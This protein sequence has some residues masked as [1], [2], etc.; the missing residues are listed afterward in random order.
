MT[1][2]YIG[3]TLIECLSTD[4]KPDAPDGWFLK[5]IDSGISYIRRNGEWVSLGLGLSFI[6]ATKS[7][8]I[9]TDANGEYTL[10]FDTPF[11]SNDYSIALTCSDTTPQPQN[12]V[13][14]ALVC[15]CA[16]CG[17]KIKTYGSKSGNKWPGV[18][19]SWLATRNYNP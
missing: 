7:G 3:G 2:V 10:V 12:G 8:Q 5:E 14:I 6:M 1:V 13:P 19:V 4:T 11:C 9:V 17:F 16:E 18:S 15:N